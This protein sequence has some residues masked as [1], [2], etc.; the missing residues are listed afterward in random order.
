M[1]QTLNPYTSTAKTAEIM[2]RYRP[3]A[4]RHHTSLNGGAS[5]GSSGGEG[6]GSRFRSCMFFHVSDYKAIILLK[7]RVDSFAI[8]TNKDK[9]KRKDIIGSTT[10]NKYYF[11]KTKNT[12]S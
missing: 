1:L 2:A 8:K 11:Q 12:T 5:G 7:K 6:E 10:I 4:P 9:K 3:I